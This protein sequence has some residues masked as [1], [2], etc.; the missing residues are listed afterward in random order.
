[1]KLILSRKGFDSSSGGCPNPIFPDGRMLAL[2][3]PDASSKVAYR[4]ISFDEFNLG[5]LVNSLSSGKVKRNHRAHLDPDLDSSAYPREPNWK[6]LLGQHGAAQGHLRNSGV[7]PGDVFVF[8]G[9]FREVEKVNRCWQFVK[10]AK[11]K[12]VIWGW[13]FVD[14]MIEV[15]ALSD[16]EKRWLDYHP[17][18]QWPDERNNTLYLASE[19]EHFGMPG[20]GIVPRINDGLILSDASSDKPSAW[21]LPEWFYPA[22]RPPLSYHLKPERWYREGGHCFLQSAAR[23]QEFVLDLDY[24]P[25]AL[26]WLKGLFN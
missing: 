13:M 14:Q 3:I 9:L 19:K 2:P 24:Y 22:N 26:S 5:S 18:L 16:N 15:A 6:P 17:H 10:T 8:F 4:D 12:H 1:M 7:G 20:S 21:N 25:E 23:G 11:P